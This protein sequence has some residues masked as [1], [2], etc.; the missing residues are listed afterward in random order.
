MKIE[1]DSLNTQHARKVEGGGEVE[2][3]GGAVEVEVEVEVAGGEAEMTTSL[4]TWVT[5]VHLFSFFRLTDAGAALS[6]YANAR[7]NSVQPSST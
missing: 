2:G 7:S 1:G 3:G 4:G 5:S 6:L